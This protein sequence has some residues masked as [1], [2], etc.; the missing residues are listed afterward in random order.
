[1]AYLGMKY[2]KKRTTDLAHANEALLE[3]I[4]EH[5]KAE[6][7]LLRAKINYR[8]IADFT[9][10]WEWW[11]NLDGTFRYVSPACERITGYKADLF[12]KDHS[13]L[14]E[15]IV[16]EDRDKWDKH[17][18]ES[19]QDSG[20]R[21]MQFRIKKA[22]GDV[23]WIEHACQPVFTR[24]NEF[25]GFRASNQDITKRKQAEE[26]LRESEEKFK[27]VVTNN[28][29][30]VYMIAKD[31]TFL[32]SEGKGLSKLGLK[33][34]QVVG[35]SIF[36]LYKDYPRMLNEM[37]R[38]FNGE[39]VTSEINIDGN[40]FRNW[41]T[42]H[43]NHE[44]EIIGLLGLSINITERMLAEQAR[45]KIEEE[46]RI[47]SA[48]LM[49]AEERER[50][51]IAGDI[52]DTIGQALSAIKFSVENS[53]FTINKKDFSAAAQ[54]L[55]SIIPLTQQ[56][57]EEV[58]R[59]IM[60]LRPSILDDLGLVATISWFCREYES[61]YTSIR[62]DKEINV[63]EADIE[64]SLKIVIYRILQEALNNAAKHSQT[65]IIHLH[66]MKN[67]DELELM[68]KDTGVGFE[69]D[70]ISSIN[71][72]EKGLGLTSMRE[73]AQLS[74]G[75][76][77][78]KSSPGMGTGLSVSWPIKVSGIYQEQPPS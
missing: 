38:A 47:L 50:K 14:R 16:P 61:I 75:T 66:L 23:R 52:H 34:G 12:I 29:E 15:I 43:K 49:T 18:N 22:D 55:E 68:V 26:T 1:M 67:Q 78:I 74:G 40:Y 31:G 42:P 58:R 57:I 62:I 36:E 64:S 17:H 11:T 63:D 25:L 13:F 53:L 5:K 59:I 19:H 3:E 20:L 51:R 2:I 35:K 9:Y 28:E 46:L 30:I 41:Y 69:L 65:D 45:Q 8:M 21:E 24:E 32:L 10:N 44:G 72:Y 7:E 56:A 54:S 60:D 4:T 39:T 33:S 27:T 48:Q 37:R 6:K 71:I 77:K 73:R 70:E 76:F